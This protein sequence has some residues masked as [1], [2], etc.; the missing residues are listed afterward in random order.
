MSNILNKK[1]KFFKKNAGFT[2][3]E[4]IVVIGI[5]AVLSTVFVINIGGQ[6]VK[7]D[8]KIAQNELV[9]NIRKT[10]SY[11]L[12]SRILPNGKLA[13]YYVLKFDTANP[14][15]Y[16]I[17][18]I[19]DASS[20]PKL[21][22]VETINFP[23]NI[24]IATTSASNLAIAVYR[25]IN[26]TI[27]PIYTNCALAAFAAPFGKVIFNDGCTPPNPG[28][29]GTSLSLAND[30]WSKIINFQNNIAC[31]GNNGNP[32]APPA[33]TASTDSSMTIT[34]AD[35]NKTLFKSV[36]INGITGAVTFN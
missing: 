7:R 21:I 30:Y 9:S 15:Q 34:I 31:D 20:S 19:Y 36:T 3:I 14:G 8:L 24:E 23:P 16:K 6:R 22:D 26:P 17:Q 18:A 1:S 12:S 28:T 10:Q 13:Q 5:L 33:C 29:G 27:Q 25:S 11:L 2:L 35:K 4:L 32:A